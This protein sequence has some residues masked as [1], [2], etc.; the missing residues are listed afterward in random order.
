VT[1]AATELDWPFT[2]DRLSLRPAVAPD[3]PAIFSYRR[4]E[5][6]AE[7][8]TAQPADEAEFADQIADKLDGTIV[9]EREGVLVGDLFFAIGDAWS[10]TE[11]KDQ[12]AGVQAEIGWCLDPAHTGRGYATEAV[13]ELLRI[14]F[15]ELGLHRVFAQCFAANEGS[16]RLM[17]RLGMRREQ[18]TKKDS[19]HRNGE[20][21]DGMMYALL[22][23][24]WRA[25]A[26]A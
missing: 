23:E 5:T 24:E 13:K 19:L 6:V 18:H 10:Q 14:S 12:A 21:L 2:T 15:E 4:L 11:V 26:V 7:W 22:A 1:S 17:E 8:M 25:G 16:W 20:W 3:M 9:I